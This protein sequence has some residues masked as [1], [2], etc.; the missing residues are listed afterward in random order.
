[1]INCDSCGLVPVPETDLPVILPD[2]EEYRPK[3]RSPLA[4]AA[5][6]VEADCP[7]C[8]A[9]GARETDTMD[10]FVDSSWYFLR[11]CDAHNSER[12]F[13]D[14]KV[15]YW[16]AVD[17][18]IGGVEH[19]VL[20]LLY[21]RFITKVLHDM[22]HSPAEE[23]FTRLFTQGMLI[24][25]GAKMSKSKGNVVTPEPYYERYGADAIRL[26][27][28]FIGPPTD[29]AVWIDGGVEGTARF[30][31]RVWRLGMG[32][33]GSVSDRDENR[34]DHAIL[35]VA[36]RA[37]RKVTADI[38]RFHF[39]TVV[40]TLMAL[41]NE[42]ISYLRAGGRAGTFREVYRLLLLMLGPL[43][44]HVSHE[45]LGAAGLRGDPGHPDM[46]G[47]GLRD[48]PGGHGGDGSPGQR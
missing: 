44:P 29:D 31:D 38:D 42:V 10:T 25:D 24:K 35:G 13:D 5:D 15:N 4:L 37:L 27:E 46:A 45:L 2:V 19:A 36:H 26:Y 16:M 48:R 39:N 20:H 32:E 11:Y 8:G 33:V 9:P 23:P 14:D 12:I 17:Q 40:S 41:I 43:A 47:V 3:G 22:G 6:W 34:R 30:L 21:A 28:L 18:Y 1:M 7:R